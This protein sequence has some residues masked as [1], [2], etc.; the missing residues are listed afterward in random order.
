MKAA[1]HHLNHLKKEYLSYI[2]DHLDKYII[3]IREFH[4]LR[5]GDDSLSDVL[6]TLLTGIETIK[7]MV[8]NEPFDPHYVNHL[9]QKINPGRKGSPKK[10]GETDVSPVEVRGSMKECIGFLKNIVSFYTF[11]KDIT[12]RVVSNLLDDFSILETKFLN[13]KKVPVFY[14]P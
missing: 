1:I 11:E 13:M 8:G 14:R 12:S 7:G 6:D 3:M 4:A 10:W 5:P 2:H 9:I